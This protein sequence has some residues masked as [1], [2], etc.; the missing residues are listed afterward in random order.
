MEV[1]PNVVGLL[2]IA[3]Y[4]LLDHVADLLHGCDGFRRH[5]DVL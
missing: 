2:D 4:F 1:E 3:G 5:D